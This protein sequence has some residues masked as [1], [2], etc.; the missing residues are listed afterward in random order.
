MTIAISCCLSDGAVLGTDSAVTITGQSQDLVLN[1]FTDAKKLFSLSNLP[2]GLTVY[3][4]AAFNDRTI[5]SYVREFVD[6]VLSVPGRPRP[7]VMRPL[8]QELHTFIRQR[9][10][11]G[12]VGPHFQLVGY[13]PGHHLPELYTIDTNQP[14]FDLGV[15][16]GASPG[17]TWGGVT[18]ALDRMH[19][20]IDSS[21]A[22]A[23]GIVMGEEMSAMGLAVTDEDLAR[24]DQRVEEVIARHSIFPNL[25]SMPIQQ[26]IDYVQSLL[27][28]MIARCRFMDGAPVCDTPINVA[29]IT[30]QDGFQEIT[31]ASFQVRTL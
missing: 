12:E 29:V 19:R 21:L 26:G 5:A 31:D 16:Q 1:T 7:T 4:A 10:T 3:G 23:I 18:D 9:N 17:I 14:D 22:Y 20:G 28:I 11:R 6:A 13:T 25:S 8:A 2:A 27:N 24:I 30:P 15:V